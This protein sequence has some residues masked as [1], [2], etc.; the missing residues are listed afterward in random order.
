M[1]V[2]WCGCRTWFI[3]NTEIKTRKSKIVCS[4]LVVN[5]SLHTRTVQ[6]QAVHSIDIYFRL[7]S[8]TRWLNTLSMHLV[9]IV[10]VRPVN[11]NWNV[12]TSLASILR[13]FLFD[14]RRQPRRRRRRQT[15]I[16]SMHYGAETICTLH[17]ILSSR[18][19]LF[20]PNF[21]LNRRI[22]ICKFSFSRSVGARVN[23]HTW[24]RQTQKK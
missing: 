7:V 6:A 19:F 10:I 2:V 4:F 17:T 9:V 21:N 16:T 22:A 20:L 15:T 18:F 5:S 12:H 14:R 23:T 13:I 1:S 11:R 3:P 8:N 24:V